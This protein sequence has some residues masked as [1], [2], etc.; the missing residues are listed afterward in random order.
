MAF[1][2][3]YYTLRIILNIVAE[4]DGGKDGNSRRFANFTPQN[5][6]GMRGVALN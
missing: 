4:V 5:M 6:A 2:D 3:R 1:K